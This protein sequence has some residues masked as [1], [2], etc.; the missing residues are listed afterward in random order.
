MENA[1]LEFQGPLDNTEVDPDTGA[2]H[3]KKG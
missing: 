3:L 1:K 2:L